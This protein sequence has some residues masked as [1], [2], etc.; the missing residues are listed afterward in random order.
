MNPESTDHQEPCHQPDKAYKNLDFL[1]SGPARPVRILCELI[2]PSVR[3]RKHDIRSTLVM[4]GSARNLPPE[5]EEAAIEEIT[6]Q[7]EDE[8]LSPDLRSQLEIRRR[9]IQRSVKYYAKARDLAF[10]LTQ[11]GLQEKDPSKRH[12]VCSGGGPGIMEAAN[13]GAAEAGGT[14]V[15]LGISLPFEQRL[16]A[17]CNEET[18]FDFHYFFLRKFWFL[19]LARALIVFPGGFGTMDELFEV[20]T[21]IQTQK[22]AKRIPILLIGSEF[23]KEVVHFEKLVE[24]GTISPEDLGL[25]RIMD[26]VEEAYQYLIEKLKEPSTFHTRDTA[27]EI[28]E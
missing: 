7:L 2:E 23:W 21:L 9:Q 13:R 22:T 8:A 4:F 12:Y 3:F 6:R 17:Y 25:F 5:R 15:A 1:N 14:S 16:N 18:S 28:F 10:K 26:D 24:W 19:Y 20:L 11:W 27:P